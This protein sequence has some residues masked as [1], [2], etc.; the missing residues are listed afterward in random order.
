MHGRIA[1]PPT[2]QLDK[3]DSFKLQVILR[4]GANVV[5]L[6]SAVRLPGSPKWVEYVGKVTLDQMYLQLLP[7]LCVS[8]V[9]RLTGFTCLCARLIRL[10]RPHWQTVGCCSACARGVSACYRSRLGDML[11][12]CTSWQIEWF[13]RPPIPWC[14]C[15][16]VGVA[17]PFES[18]KRDC[19]SATCEQPVGN[20]GAPTGH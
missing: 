4:V 9:G 5:I 7:T 2:P 6:V 14:L 20:D 3:C 10:L 13:R 18:W 19:V 11:V 15:A 17:S 16:E 1:N 12:R 8:V